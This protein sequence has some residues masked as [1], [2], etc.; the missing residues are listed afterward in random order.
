MQLAV[1]NELLSLTNAK[2]YYK[3]VIMLE[4]NHNMIKEEVN[5]SVETLASK[6]QLTIVGVISIVAI[7]IGIL[8]FLI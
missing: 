5:K 3:Q 7:I 8:N 6:K 4:N 1:Y 2:L